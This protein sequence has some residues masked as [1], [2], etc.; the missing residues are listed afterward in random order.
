MNILVCTDGSEDSQKALEVASNIAMGCN[1]DDV[2][3]IHVY[4]PQDITILGEA[5]TKTTIENF[6]KLEEKRK[7]EATNIL[8]KALKFIEEKN[9]K[10]RTI[11]EEGHPAEIILRVASEQGFDMIVVGGRGAGS[12]KK[13]FL[14]SIS[15]ALIQE[16]KNCAVVVIK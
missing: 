5:T 11:F 3:I 13:L 12:L 7:E 4:H 16:A 1:P 14:G 10:A 2:A 15:S 8:L 9:I 6:I